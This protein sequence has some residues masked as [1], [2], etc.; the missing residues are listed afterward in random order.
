MAR[1]KEFD[2]DLALGR[3]I[4]LF[5]ER[6]F[7]GTSTEDIMQAMGIGRQSMYDTFG[8]KRT[9]FLTALDQYVRS[10][11]GLIANELRKPGN[12]LDLLRHTLITFAQREDL[13]SVGACMGLN[14]IAEFGI[15]DKEV[16]ETITAAASV[17]RVAVTD[18]VR[19]GVAEG[20][21]ASRNSVAVVD[22]FEAALAGIRFAAKAG[23]PRRALQNLAEFSARALHGDSQTK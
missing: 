17:Q 22:F 7:A 8:D 13:S 23:K 18:L 16:T 3:A 6:G 1:N 5:S 20:V 9:L 14:T 4:Q 12:P 15:R 11:S 2:R 21:I 10:S 19:R